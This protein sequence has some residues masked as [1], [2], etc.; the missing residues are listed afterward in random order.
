MTN[1]V[2]FDL[3]TTGV[4]PFRDVPV[5]FGFVSRT[6]HGA[7]DVG[8]VNPG[9]AIPAGAAA[10]HGITD[11]MVAEAPSLEV[12]MK[13]ISD[14]LRDVW[15]QGGVIVG[16]NVAYDLTM[17]DATCR[18]L[19]MPALDDAPGVGPV[20]DVLILDRH[21]DKWRKGAR[22]LTDL[23]RHYGVALDGAHSAADDALASLEVYEAIARQFPEVD[24]ISIS[25]LNRELGSWYREWLTSFSTYL[26]KKGEAPIGAGRYE[27]PIHADH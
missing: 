26:E 14:R 6:A 24:S 3:E 17:V 22:K 4:D 15:D 13:T 16:M 21:F 18:R 9:R 10:I 8:L 20:I 1:Y 23:C 27:W 25:D 7:N 11:T 5:S 12:A 2:A 19:S